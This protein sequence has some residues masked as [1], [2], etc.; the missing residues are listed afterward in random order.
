MN[1][2]SSFI[3]QK[4]FT[5][6]E[7]MVVIVIV[8]IMAS[9]IMLNIDGVDHR[10]ALQAREFLLLDLKKINRDANDQAQIYALDIL[11]AT[12]VAPFRYKLVQ[13]QPFTESADKSLRVIEGKPWKDVQNFDLRSLPER[14][15]FV[16]QS[17]EHRFVNANNADLLGNNAPKVIWFGNGEAKPVKIQ[18]YYDQKPIG[19]LID[20]DYLGKVTDEE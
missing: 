19:A 15:S 2:P 1:K 10:K 14:V 6:I 18:M 16:V 13:Y 11:P 17:Q 4:G 5:L 9:L 20:L 7:L 3:L 8:S 12:D